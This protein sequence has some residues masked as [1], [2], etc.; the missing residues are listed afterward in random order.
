MKP[1]SSRTSH[2]TDSCIRRMTRLSMQYNAINLSQG[3]PDFDP[4]KAIMDRLTSVAQEG[5]HQYSPTWGFAEY[6]KALCD[7]VSCYMGI[8]LNPDENILATVGST[9]AMMAALMAITDPGDKVACFSPFFEN[10]EAQSLLLGCTPVYVPL[11]PPDNH[12]DPNEVEDA[13]RAGCKAMIICNPS[14]PNGKVFEKEEL[15]TIAQLAIKYDVYII[16][17]EVYEH[18]IYAPFV[19]TYMAT[20]PGMWERTVCCSSL[21]KTYSITGWRLGYIAACKRIVDACKKTH[22]YLTVCA[23]S[24]LQAA[25]IAG[26]EM[27]ESY[28]AELQAHYTHMKDLFCGGLRDIGLNFIEPQGTYFLLVDIGEYAHGDDVAFCERM[29]IE[30]GVAVVPGSTFYR[31]DVRHLAR[32]HFAKKDETLLA[33]LDRLSNIRSLKN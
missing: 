30:L 17:D 24:P 20:L 31:E 27:P 28:Y 33:A 12:F 14:N 5:P 2:I 3:F 21:S 10:Y 19:H 4:P 6:R 29:A 13:F 7:K 26:L 32:F 8:P 1:L 16:M 23:P 11:Y 9:E 25:V 22:D 18:I 15:E